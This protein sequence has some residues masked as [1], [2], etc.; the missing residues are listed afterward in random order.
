MELYIPVIPTQAKPPR[1]WLLIVQNSG[2][3]DNN[4]VN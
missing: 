1:V 2:T 3:G 4:T